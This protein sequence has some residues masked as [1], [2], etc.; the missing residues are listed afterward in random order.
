MTQQEEFSRIKQLPP[1]IFHHVAQLKANVAMQGHDI[2]DFGIGNPDQPPAPHIRQ[3]LVDALDDPEYHRYT[4]SRGILP[5][6]E[7]IAKWYAARY[8]VEID[9][10]TETVV[11]IG[12]KEGL[13]HI[14]LAVTG[15]GDNII[16]PDPSYPIHR[17]GFVVSGANLVHVPLQSPEQFLKDV[18]HMALAIDPKPK[19]ILVNFPA[20]P[21]THV[22]DIDFFE[23]LVD[24]ARAHEIYIIQ[25]LAYADIV[26]SD[27]KA[28]SILQ[29]PHAKEVAVETF[30]LSK[31]YNMPGWRVGFM[32]GNPKL[33]HA[34]A[35]LKTYF[36][37]GHFGPVQHAAL[38][39]LT[40]PQD[41]VKQTCDMY[42]A[43]RDLLCSELAAVG[44]DIPPP[45]STMFVWAKIPKAFE[46]L[47]S[48][49][50]VTQ[51]IEKAHVAV[52][53][54]IGFGQFGNDHVRFS[55]VQ[56]DD[57]CREAVKRI[58]KFLKG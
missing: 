11:T 26:F 57:V 41:C 30:T 18:K 15:P 25:D 53:P 33:I 22:V 50:F 24:F 17:Y 48:L 14:A 10:V 52:S 27:K 2:I 51:L 49:E 4:E 35:H 23:E 34:L 56:E 36:D 42:R 58:A 9:P 37:Y 7:A 32:S 3:A 43:R 20:N 55:L 39:A 40:G 29:V 19:M 38:A 1:Y 8:Q 44:W 16:V 6:R 54:G 5:L 47:G 46:D 21:S 13:S 31:S 45:E 12:S 28:P